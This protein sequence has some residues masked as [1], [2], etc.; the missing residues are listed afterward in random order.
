MKVRPRSKPGD[1]G[2]GLSAGQFQMVM[3]TIREAVHVV[4]R[5]LRILFINRHFH[6][7]LE[8]MG[9]SGE[10]D[11]R[12]IMEVF[13][14][15][16]KGVLQE[17]RRVIR[18]GVALFTEESN[19]VGGAPVSTETQKIPIVV[20]GRVT[21]VVT[22]VRDITKR[23]RAEADLQALNRSLDEKVVERTAQLRE[24][25]EKYRTLLDHLPV[26]VYRTTPGGRF[27][28][29]S[30]TLAGMLGYRSPAALGKINIRD[31]YVDPGER[32]RH[33]RILGRKATEPREFALKRRD[34]SPV[35]VRDHPRTIKDRRGRVM[36]YDGILVDISK[37]RHAERAL[38]ATEERYR[39]LV[40]N[41]NS[42]ILRLDPEGRVTFWNRFAAKFFGFKPAEVLG[43]PV[44]GTIVPSRE[45][46][47]R[48]LK[49]LL[50][51]ICLHPERHVN[52]VNENVKKNGERVWIAW[53]NRPF[54]DEDGKFA[55]ALCVGNDLTRIKRAEDQLRQSHE[56]LERRVAERTAELLRANAEL[57]RQIADRQKAERTLKESEE[58]FREF[59]D[60]NVAAS[61]ICAR[62]GRLLQVNEAFTR[63]FG[64][65]SIA[66]AKGARGRD[67]YLR[68]ADRRAF[69][70][71]I[72]A[73]RSLTLEEMTYRT[74][75]GSPFTVL[76]SAVGAFDARG[77][78]TQ[79]L[80]YMVDVTQ[81]RTAED[82]LAHLLHH[83]PLTGLPNRGLLMDRMEQAIARARRS[84]RMVGLAVLDLDRFNAVNDTFGHRAGD[85]LIQSLAQRLLEQSEDAD[86]VAHL[87]GDAFALLFADL[88]GP[89][90]M[91][92][93]PPQVD[94]VLARPFP[95]EKQ[96]IYARAS[97]GITLFPQDAADGQ[98]LLKN[99]EVA[100]YQAKEQGGGHSQYYRPE[101]NVL[102][103]ERMMMETGLRKGLERGEF[104]LHY[105]PLVDLR[106]R[107]I[108]GVEALMRWQHPEL[109]LLYPASFIPLAE[110][111]GVIVPMGEWALQEACAQAKRWADQGFPL[112]R[113]NVNLSARHF[114][115]KDLAV[116]VGCILAD[117]GL[118]PRC[119]ELELTENTIMANVAESIRIMN[120]LKGQGV[121]LAIDDFGTGYSSLFYLKKHFPVDTLKIDR[122]FLKDVTTNPDDA[123][124]VQAILAMG[125]SL[126]MEVVAEGVELPEQVEFLRHNGCH[127]I[128]GF[129]C[130]R[131]REPGAVEALLKRG[132]CPAVG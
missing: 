112:R 13:P 121:R 53:T 61:Y 42:I 9:L 40:E 72:R 94:E 78:L 128:Q 75:D 129:I 7:W 46:T 50:E 131:P 67:M 127:I 100:M 86:T 66:E 48:D 102:N 116:L 83:D 117:T 52:N 124:I 63:L 55:G 73:R 80:G 104:R 4:D 115:T 96:E 90:R 31:L 28:Q 130:S 6:A 126:R 88:E 98:G 87:D 35:W 10:T 64:Y 32:T 2:A 120:E 125:K 5:D 132:T 81:L 47:G 99:A 74:R 111:R 91:A 58:R 16:P 60:R 44:V 82:R 93:I 34:G 106:S 49:A 110:E 62:D 41:A 14:F 1:G 38:R 65:A 68:S 56:E 109:G 97:V 118:D 84:G 24:S 12:T 45:S 79:I 29:A 105:Q 37:R 108:V 107:R 3:D 85:L 15:L 114:Q 18:T 23:K 123:A 76:E 119:L 30:K 27:L 51:D 95:I 103:L 22:I 33:L 19:R 77:R 113:L 122:F 101:M 59:F 43:R 92:S 36:H 21:A 57:K 69:L 39:D 11:G 17:Y 89:E 8:G 20:G 71:K 54:F 70:E 26:G 25:E